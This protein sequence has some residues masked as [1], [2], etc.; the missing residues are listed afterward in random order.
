MSRL[1]RQAWLGSRSRVRAVN[2][3]VI[4]LVLAFLLWLGTAL[5]AAAATP[6]GPRLAISLRGDGPGPEDEFSEVIRTVPAGED[7]QPL[8]RGSGGSIGEG[9]SWARDGSG[10][11]FSEGGVESTAD[12]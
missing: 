10:F 5:P 9:L 4:V 2:G 3:R 6:E 8:L 1:R 7:P 12:G 11:A